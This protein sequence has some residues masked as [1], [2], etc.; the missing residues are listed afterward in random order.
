MGKISTGNTQELK[1]AMTK[2]LNEFPGELIC[3]RQIWYEGLGGCGVP[4]P[5]DMDAMEA[6]F[7]SLSDWKNV[8][9]TRYEKF[10]AQNSWKRSK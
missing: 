5:A 9:M 2:W 10:G 6:V 7:N 4:N 1:S 3:A 8:G